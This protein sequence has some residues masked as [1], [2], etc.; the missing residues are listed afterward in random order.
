[1]IDKLKNTYD[2][3]NKELQKMENV[4]NESKQGFYQRVPA[5]PTHYQQRLSKQN[6]SIEEVTF[7]TQP[8]NGHS[9]QKSEN[10]KTCLSVK[11]EQF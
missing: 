3:Q 2:M 9:K 1:M 6:G 11:S 5:S 10:G 7:D 4:M 8:M